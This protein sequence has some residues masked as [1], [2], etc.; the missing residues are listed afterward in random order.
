MNLFWKNRKYVDGVIFF[1]RRQARKKAVVSILQDLVEEDQVDK[2]PHIVLIDQL[3][4]FIGSNPEKAVSIY[5][6]NYIIKF[7]F[8]F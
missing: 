6:Y 7:F 3:F 5:F 1:R 8:F 2:P 4:N